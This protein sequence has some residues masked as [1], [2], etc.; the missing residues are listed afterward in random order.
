MALSQHDCGFCCCKL[1]RFLIF[2]KRST[3]E[4][5]TGSRRKNITQTKTTQVN[6]LCPHQQLEIKGEVLR[7]LHRRLGTKVHAG[8][9]F[10]I[11]VEVQRIDHRVRR[12]FG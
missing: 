5:F 2:C 12:V 7:R 10:C 1:I 4:K 9:P 11:L 6:P 8:F 3:Y